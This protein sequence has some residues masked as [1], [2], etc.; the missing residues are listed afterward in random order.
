MREVCFQ[1]QFFKSQF[2]QL[3][4]RN[5][6]HQQN[7]AVNAPIRGRD[8]KKT[9]VAVAK[10][11]ILAKRARKIPN[12]AKRRANLAK[13]APDLDL[14]VWVPSLIRIP[15]PNLVPILT[16]IPHRIRIPVRK[17][18]KRVADR[19]E[20]M[21]GKNPANLNI[22][23]SPKDIVRE[24]LVLKKSIEN[25][26]RKIKKKNRKN[27]NPKLKLL[28]HQL[29][30]NLKKIIGLS[31]LMDLFFQRIFTNTTTSKF[32][33]TTTNWIWKSWLYEHAACRKPLWKPR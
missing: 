12:A 5:L 22:E 9:P 3:Y 29:G 26:H 27:A 7:A 24:I 17:I 18:V 8:A 1:S 4:S 28:F 19:A 6:S 14:W 25:H 13:V 31:F 10:D 15:D 21:K 33:A 32:S 20:K 11:P 23:K 16:T 30:K 2:S